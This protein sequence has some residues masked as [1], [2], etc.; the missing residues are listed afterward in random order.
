MSWPGALVAS[1]GRFA[2]T[3]ETGVRDSLRVSC[4]NEDQ[5]GHAF[6]LR[7]APVPTTA[8]WTGWTRWSSAAHLHV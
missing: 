7:G 4:V 3:R 2:S 8:F 6:R 5:H 1:P